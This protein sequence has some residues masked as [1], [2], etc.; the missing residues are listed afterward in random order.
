MSLRR[1]YE[2]TVIVN[3]ALEDADVDAVV[4]KITTYIENH[5]GEILE[6]EKW[7]RRRLAYPIN[8]KF[9][10]FYVHIIFEALTNTIPILER[11]LVLEDTILRH[12]TL[13][14]PQK[15]RDYRA[16]KITGDGRPIEPAPEDEEATADIAVV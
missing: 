4:A 1:T 14:L 3:A 2:T 16:K 13:I 6:V 11:F 5:G 7:G 10:G 9:N 8:K 12:L 15:L